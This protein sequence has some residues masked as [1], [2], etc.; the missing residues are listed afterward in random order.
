[1]A[2]KLFHCDRIDLTCWAGLLSPPDCAALIQIGRAHLQDATVTDEDSG[3][4]VSHPQRV[5]QMAWPKRE[6]YPLL[7]R[8]AA[9][10]AQLTGVSLDCQEPLQILRY[11]PGGEYRPHFDA[12]A[13]DSPALRC[14]GNRQWTLIFYLNPVEGGG[15]TCFP[16]LGLTVVPLPGSGIVFRNLNAAGVREPLALHAGNPVTQGEKWI[17]TQWIRERAYVDPR[18]AG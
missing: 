17:A 10:I 14:G 15:E 7:Q 9:G 4:A 3:E 18:A 13:T 6:Q 5:S 8:M 16:E 2:Q 11:L 12:F 1:M